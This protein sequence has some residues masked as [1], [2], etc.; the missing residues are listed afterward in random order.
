MSYT[1]AFLPTPDKIFHPVS[2]LCG[3]RL[4]ELEVNINICLSNPNIP[5]LLR[6][7]SL[8]SLLSLN[9]LPISKKQP[10]LNRIHKKYRSVPRTVFTYPGSGLPVED[11]C[12]EDPEARDDPGDGEYTEDGVAGGG[13]LG[14]V[15]QL[16]RLQE[17]VREVM[18]NQD[19]RPA[20][21]VR[22]KI[23]LSIKIFF[24]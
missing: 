15:A 13:E 12:G 22:L 10:A 20:P 19:Q 7:L 4:H 11:P 6:F 3:R 17:Y 2:A 14:V 21:V 18:N 1:G 5:S 16:G 24:Y 23:T 9:S 8:P